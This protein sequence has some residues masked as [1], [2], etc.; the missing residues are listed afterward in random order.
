M[1]IKP[2]MEDNLYSSKRLVEI[3][4]SL[5]ILKKKSFEYLDQFEKT[6]FN[7]IIYK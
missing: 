7:I 3:S 1:D 5:R 4:D 2:S 6:C